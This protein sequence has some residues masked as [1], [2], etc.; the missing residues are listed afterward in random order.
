MVPNDLQ[1]R[2]SLSH[3]LDSPFP[4]DYI[5][6]GGGT[7]GL[8]LASRLTEDPSITVGVIE[9]GES[10][11]R[12]PVV[13]SPIGVSTMLHNPQYDWMF[14]STPQT[15]TNDRV[16]NISCGR[17][18]GGSSGTNFMTY[19]K[20][21]AEN[22]DLWQ[23]LGNPGWSWEE[24]SPYYHR[25]QSLDDE[26]ER[27]KKVPSGQ[28]R[29]YGRTGPIKTS[30][31]PWQLAIEESMMDAFNKI[32]GIPRPKDPLGGHHLGLY[33]SVS[34]IDRAND[35]VRSYATTGYLLP[36]LNRSNL[37]VVTGGTVCKLHLQKDSKRAIGVEF[38]CDGAFHQVSVAREVILSA[39]SIQSPKLLE[40]SGIGDPEVLQMAGI[41][42]VVPLPG[43][44]QNLREHPM[45]HVTYELTAGGG[46]PPAK[47]HTSV[48]EEQGT[49]KGR[50][51]ELSLVGFLPFTSLV[52]AEELES[53][54][55][56]AIDHQWFALAP[57]EQSIIARLRDPKSAAVQFIGYPSNVTIAEG[58]PDED[59]TKSDMS[60]TQK[61]FY[62]IL[63]IAT[64]PLSKGSCHV[65]SIDPFV[66]P[67]INLGVLSQPIDVDILAAGIAFAHRA[68]QSDRVA[69]K[70]AERVYPKPQVDLRDRDQGCEFVRLST[71]SFNHPV[72]TCAM[73]HVVDERLRVKGVHGLRVVDASVIPVHIDANPMPTVYAL[74]EKASDLI[75]EDQGVLC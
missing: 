19:C 10:K 48:D 41:E 38:W 56:K 70:I 74:A 24:L 66:P 37:R 34:T 72:G 21:S 68:L 27:P 51:G 46:F 3:F 55:S 32:S 23:N 26:T 29:T 16:H 54:I 45:T 58:C 18:L 31:S 62:S 9:A 73:G 30:F 17:V 75:K 63:V 61:T 25:S 50:P 69:D 49:P 60:Q 15:G 64:N 52:A 42:C 57:A 11:L 8:V 44:G 33:Q 28:R 13:D 67:E 71:M 39:G 35:G 5:I 6:V 47:E 20:P 65:K 2:T 22:I 4:F 36:C 53:T 7:A 59:T 40:L 14:K 43:V 1:I 12:D